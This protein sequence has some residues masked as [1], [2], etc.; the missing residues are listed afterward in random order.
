MLNRKFIV[1]FAVT[2]LVFLGIYTFA[3]NPP[4]DEPKDDETGVKEEQKTP[5]EENIEGENIE[6]GEEAEE[7]F[8]EGTG[9][10]L[11]FTPGRI[12]PTTSSVTNLPEKVEEDTEEPVVEEEVI[13]LSISGV[14]EGAYYNDEQQLEI[15]G[16]NIISVKRNGE[17]VGFT[18][19]NYSFSEEAEY[20]IVVTDNDNNTISVNFVIDTTVPSIS[21]IEENTHT[22]NEVEITIEDKNLE[23]VLVNDEIIELDENN[24]FVL[25]EEN[26]YVVIVTDKANNQTKV[27]FVIDKTAPEV[28]LNGDKKIYLEFNQDYYDDKGATAT[29]TFT[30]TEELIFRNLIEY[31]EVIDGNKNFVKVSEI[32]NTKIGR[33]KVWYYFKDKAGNE[34]NAI[35]NVYVEDTTSPII[36]LIG[37]SEII[38]NP[39]IFYFDQ[40]ATATDNY[41]GDL[42]KKIKKTGFVNPLI[43]GKYTITYNVTDSNGNE[44]EPVSRTVIV[45]DTIKPTVLLLPYGN[46][47]AAKTHSTWVIVLDNHRVDNDSLKYIWT[48]STEAPTKEE[49][50]NEFRNFNVIKSPSD[51]N[52]TYY[53]WIY[54]KDVSGNETIVSSKAFNFDN[55][56][57]S[58]EVNYSITEET[59]ENVVVTISANEKMQ[60]V[61]GWTLSNDKKELKKDYKTNVSNERV[62]LKDLLGNSTEVFISITNID[63]G[64]PDFKISRNIPFDQPTNQDVTLTFAIAYDNSGGFG[65]HDEPY[66]FDGGK[67]WTNDSSKTFSKN[68]SV[69]VMLRDKVGNTCSGSIKITNIDKETPVVTYNDKE[70]RTVKETITINP[71]G[72]YDVEGNNPFLVTDNSQEGYLE[73]YEIKIRYA[74]EWDGQNGTYNGKKVDKVDLGLLGVYRIDYKYKD[75]AGNKTYGAVWIYVVVGE[76]QVYNETKQILY[77][78]IQE[79]INEADEGNTILV[80]PGEYDVAYIKES[81]KHYLLI[82]KPIIIK[83]AEMD[84]K[85]ILVGDYNQIQAQGSHQQATIEIY[86]TDN[87]TLDGLVIH[88]IENY[89]STFTKALEITNSN[90]TLINNCT[91]YDEGRTAIYIAGNEVGKYTI[92]NNNLDGSIVVANGAGD[93][94]G[95]NEAII[96]N[97]VI[98]GSISFTGKTNSGWDPLSI[99]EYP[100]IKNNVINGTNEGML[101][102]SRDSDEGNLISNDLLNM[103]IENNEFPSG[104]IGIMKDSYECY[105]AELHRKR[106]ILNPLIINTTTSFSYLTLQNA[107][108]D[109]NEGDTIKLFDHLQLSSTINISNLNF[110]LDLNGHSLTTP[111]AEGS[112]A[113]TVFKIVGESNVTI[114]GKGLIQSGTTTSYEGFVNMTPTIH[115]NDANSSL[116]IDNATI[117]GGDS[118]NSR[119]T[120][121][122]LWGQNFKEINII[123][124]TILGGDHIKKKDV[125]IGY[126]N[127]ATAGYAIDLNVA[128][129]KTVNII[130]STISGGNGINGGYN[131][132]EQGEGYKQASGG[133]AFSMNQTNEINIT[134]STIRG[135]HSDLHHGGHAIVR[136]VGKFDIKASSLVGG[137]GNKENGYSAGKGVSG[138]DS[139]SGSYTIDENSTIIDGGSS[140]S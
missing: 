38:M 49:F 52:G 116:T 136:G 11:Q 2:V 15:K 46:N 48:D 71:D 86:N 118:I 114:Q 110:T 88:S 95:A 44:A 43:P 84:N 32:D 119:D 106:L 34:G 112:A 30:A 72:E 139:G 89:P 108:N 17:S 125:G 62:V 58:V 91:I 70:Q 68:Q 1:A 42:T 8:E 94:E 80:G 113:Q 10:G 61:D 76:K 53:L 130:R 111:D 132:F 59:N 9:S 55:E 67:T 50:S 127:Y 98:N 40:G 121:P 45:K 83:A 16:T 134:N 81:K 41:D 66:S 65:L 54:A 35:R 105:D 140:N 29:D 26:E 27:E 4:A 37:D 102:N 129:G 93:G 21:G 63:K 18:G 104:E 128:S 33:Y 96:K 135:G 92:S 57:P 31:V 123:D 19:G 137:N 99:N 23:S 107:I 51:L 22:N 56:G 133:Q 126:N 3:L 14:E 69:N 103:I 82:E 79:A 60:K 97:N 24:K 100:N 73:P 6:E 28:K 5:K 101:L 138:N 87:V 85:P 64:K 77:D 109:A 115:I 36:E 117:K 20:E 122:A 78:V 124:A 90:N 47:K 74:P 13:P 39:S 75:E 12:I 25:S 131:T 120:A 7:E